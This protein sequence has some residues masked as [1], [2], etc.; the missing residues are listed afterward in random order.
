MIDMARRMLQVSD[1]RVTFHS[2]GKEAL[3][4][5]SFGMD[6][7][8]RLGLVG[9]S[10]SGK[11]VTAM[12]ISGLI[13]RSNVTISGTVNFEGRDLQHCP[14][15]ELRRVQGKEIGVVFQEPMNSLNPLMKIGRQVEEVLR[16]HTDMSPQEQKKLALQT[17]DRVGLP[18]PE[19]IYEKYP[20]QISGGQRQRVMI[21]AAVII[22]PK[23]LICDE[24]TTALDV[25]VQAKILQLLRDLSEEYGVAILLISHNLRVVKNLC[26]K[27]AVMRRGDIVERGFTKDV[28]ENPQHEYT[29]ELM[30]PIPGRLRNE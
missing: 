16:I 3:H 24:P 29:R 26:E 21:A 2:T 17:L 11:T 7:G 19:E 10:G 12:A 20:H 13:D 4:G 6:C 27:V 30:K 5:I 15:S 8:E 22:K 25:S 18:N 23:L 9:E 14:R 1:L 28:F